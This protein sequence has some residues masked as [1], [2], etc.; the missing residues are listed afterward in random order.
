MA[1]TINGSGSIS[2]ISAGGIADAGA[3]ADS[4][5]GAGAVL[6]VVQ[7]T[8]STEQT[9]TSSAYADTG[10]TATITPTSATSKIL[11]LVDHNGCG[12]ASANAYMGMKLLR[13]A[14]DLITLGRTM[15]FTGV[16]DSNYWGTIS[17]SYLDSPATTSATTYKTQVA[18]IAST[19]YVFLQLENGGITPVST[20]TLMEI[21]A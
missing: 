9:I 12:K 7:G 17:T 19:G 14:T 2:G 4:A 8:Y 20:I 6:Q 18:N 16:S 3:I 15:G 13:G 11:V 21:A 1:I 5:M 10:L